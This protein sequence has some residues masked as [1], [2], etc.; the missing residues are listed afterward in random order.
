MK[1]SHNAELR[2][3]AVGATEKAFESIVQTSRVAEA[4]PGQ[5]KP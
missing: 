5:R 2:C 3:T 4:L 1:N